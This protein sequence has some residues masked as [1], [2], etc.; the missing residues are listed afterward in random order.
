MSESARESMRARTARQSDATSRASLE[1]AIKLYIQLNGRFAIL[2]RVLA[3]NGQIVNS[4]RWA[5]HPAKEPAGGLRANKGTPVAEPLR[6][7]VAGPI[8]TEKA[9]ILANQRSPASAKI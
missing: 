8:C 3:P 7:I 9:S 5:S 1:A 4:H 6:Q 2:C